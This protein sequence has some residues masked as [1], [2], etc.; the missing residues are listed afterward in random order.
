MAIISFQLQEA[1]VSAD[2]VHDVVSE[3][4]GLK[5]GLKEKVEGVL[6]DLCKLSD[7]AHTAK[8]ITESSLRKALALIGQTLGQASVDASPPE[9][10]DVKDAHMAAKH[11]AC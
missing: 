9:E 11:G 10:S 7:E 8:F 2:N 5:T 3:N 1:L 6:A 4:P